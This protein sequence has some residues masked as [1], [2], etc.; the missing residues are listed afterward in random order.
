VN[1]AAEEKKDKGDTAEAEAAEKLRK[2]P[3]AAAEELRKEVRQSRMFSR[4]PY[5]R[6]LTELLLISPRFAD[7][8]SGGNKT[9]TRR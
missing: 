8:C 2:N 1:K 5:N 6:Q 3:V 7:S 9:M 4:F